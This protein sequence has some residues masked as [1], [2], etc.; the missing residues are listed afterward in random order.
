LLRAPIITVLLAFLLPLSAHAQTSPAP[1]PALPVIPTKTFSVADDGAVGDGKTLDTAALQKAIDAVARAG[2]GTLLL[3][4][5]KYLTGPLVLTSN[6]NLQLAKGAVL[7]ISDNLATYPQDSHGYQSS[8]TAAHAHDLE[9]S[10]Q[11]II[12]GQGEAWWKAFEADKAMTHRPYL[13]KLERCNRV[14]ITGVTLQN[15][16]MFHLVPYRCADVTIR[17]V[18]ITAPATA[19]NTDGIDPSGTHYL[20]D[21]CTIDTGDDNIAIKPGGAEINQNFTITHCDF[22]HG[23]GLSI[24]SGTEGGLDHLSVTDCTF[25]GTTAGIRI[26]TLRGHGGLLQNLTYDRLTMTG[27]QNPIEI[28]DYY[29]KLPAT[30]TADPAQP[31]TPLTPQFAAITIKNLISTKSPNAGTIWGLPEMPISGIT[32]TNVH[33]SAALG[34]KIVH[35]RDI[36]FSDSDI[37]TDS[38]PKLILSDAQPTGLN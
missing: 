5:G 7:L 30:P 12:D 35:A 14:L 2:G 34:L 26:K 24:G 22:R 32:F 6:L 38:G 9:I 20:I 33:L 28:V 3:P 37:K 19:H 15:S 11:G 36:H 10:G 16:P 1:P 17:G 8:L 27:V 31:V 18:T 23:H 29:P 4:P 21:G 13:I 25:E